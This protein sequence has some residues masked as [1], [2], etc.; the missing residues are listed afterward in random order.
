[1]KKNKVN[2]TISR[3]IDGNSIMQDTMKVFNQ[4]YQEVLDNI[5]CQAHSVA[6]GHMFR[7]TSFSFSLKD[8]DFAIERLNS[9]TGFGNV[10]QK[11]KV[12]LPQFIM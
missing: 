6:T 3:C 10:H 5:K 7:R 4:K 12:L 9:G 11:I 8:I 2:T 1:M